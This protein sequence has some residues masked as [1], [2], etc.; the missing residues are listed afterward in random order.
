MIYAQWLHSIEGISAAVCGNML[1]R[2]FTA[3]EIYRMREEEL[4]AAGLFNPKQISALLKAKEKDPKEEWEKLEEAGIRFY[5]REKGPYPKKLRRIREA[6]YGLYVIGSLP[7]ETRYTAAVVGARECTTYGAAVSKKIG[8]E[9]ARSGVNI[10]SGMARGADGC[11]Q[12]GALEGGGKTYAV[13]GCGIDQIYPTQNQDLYRGIPESGGVISEYPPGVIPYP[14]YFPQRNR[15]ISGLSDCVIV[16]EARRRSGS[17]ITAE[18]AI[19]QGKDVYAVPGPIDSALSYGC[20]HLIHQ[21]AGIYYSTAEFLHDKSLDFSGFAP[22][23]AVR[24]LEMSQ[25]IVYSAI[26]LLPK[27]LEEIK[28]ET[29]MS[30]RILLQILLDLQ[31]KGLIAEIGKG[32]YIRLFV[33]DPQENEV[34]DHGQ[35]SGYRGVTGESKDD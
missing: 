35:E 23:E 15:I 7:D 18:L 29:G 31:L 4:I 16:A 27:S 3:E 2:G 30:S 19:E 9:L 10:V 25:R 17:L 28:K 32:R 5:S 26:V 22:P 8:M 14:I 6:P 12:R 24:S 1:G 20:H 11:A 33:E 34:E 21:G 13:L